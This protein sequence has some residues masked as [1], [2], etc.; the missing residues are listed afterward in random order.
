MPIGAYDPESMNFAAGPAAEPASNLLRILT[1][2]A[3]AGTGGLE[4]NLSLWSQL[5]EEDRQKRLALAS[6]TGY[7]AT[8]SPSGTDVPKEMVHP[9]GALGR[10][11]FGEPT[12]E[13]MTVDELQAARYGQVLKQKRLMDA[14]EAYSKG[15]YRQSA[16][17]RGWQRL[18]DTR[19]YR[20]KTLGQGERRLGLQEQGLGLEGGRMGETQRHNMSE[21][22]ISGE[23]GLRARQRFHFGR[24]CA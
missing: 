10:A 2:A 5:A 20:E 24:A 12:M 19:N 11:V 13:S 17:E 8:S 4:G 1:I 21:E 7:D 22:N 14:L 9:R 23:A 18:E 6:K 15:A 3:K 16:S